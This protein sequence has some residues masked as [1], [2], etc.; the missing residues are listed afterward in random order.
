MDNNTSLLLGLVGLFVGAIAVIVFNYFRNS[1]M[2]KKAE[3]LL[4]KAQKDADKLKRDYIAEAL[5]LLRGNTIHTKHTLGR[6]ISIYTRMSN[7]LLMH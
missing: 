3:S 1:R 7:C 5:G 4:D 2:T 6:R